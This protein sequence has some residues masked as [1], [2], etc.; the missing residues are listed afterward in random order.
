MFISQ[1]LDDVLRVSDKVT[2]F[3]N[4]R[5]VDGAPARAVDKPWMIE[6]M[7]GAGHERLGESHNGA[8]LQARSEAAVVL[9]AERLT[10]PGLFEDVS[11]N[12]RAGEV[13]GIYGFMGSGQ[14]ELARALSGKLRLHRGTVRVDGAA[15]R[16]AGGVPA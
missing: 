4:G 15:A 3:R 10:V 7:V 11:L 12:V 5:R 2:V 13:L 16:L 8:E 1:F 9:D 6:R 14:L